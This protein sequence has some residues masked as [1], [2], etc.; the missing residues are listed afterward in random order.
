M[1]LTY[2]QAVVL[3]PLVSVRPENKELLN[4]IAAAFIKAGKVPR[5]EK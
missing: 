3:F 2:E 1:K 5:E 4:A